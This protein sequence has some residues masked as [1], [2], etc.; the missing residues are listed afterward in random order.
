MKIVGRRS[1]AFAHVVE[2]LAPLPF[3]LVPFT[4]LMSWLMRDDLPTFRSVV[5]ISTSVAAAIAAVAARALAHRTG[6]DRADNTVNVVVV[7]AALAVASSVFGM[8]TWVASG[9]EFTTLALFMLFPAIACAIGASV[10]AGRRWMYCAFLFPSVMWTPLGMWASDDPRLRGMTYIA[11]FYLAC[12][13]VVHQVATR[14][15]MEA[16]RF[17]SRSEALLVHLGDER[18][19]LGAVNAQ[20]SASNEMLAQLASN[21]PLTGLLNRRGTFDAIDRMLEDASRPV[22]LLFC[23]LDRFKSVNDALGHRGGDQFLKVL[24][25][26]IARSLAPG[27]V[28]GRIG[29]DEFVVALPGCDA[30]AS[31]VIAARLLAVLAQPV[32]AE[33]RDLPSSVSIGVAEFPAHGCTAND[34]LRNA[35]T[36]LYRAKRSGRSR[37]EMFDAAMQAERDEQL[38]AEHALRRAIENGEILPFFQPEID[39]STGRIVGAEMLARWLRPDGTVTNAADFIALAKR[40][41]LLERLTERMILQARPQIRR[42]ASLGLPDGFRFRVNLPPSSTTLSWREDPLDALVR[43]IDASLLTVDVREAAVAD[44]IPTAAAT[45]AAFR[46]RGGRVCLDDFA[47]GVSSLSLLRSLADRRGPDRPQGDRRDHCPPAR[48]RDRPIDHRGRA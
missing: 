17:Q 5:W 34:L 22:G 7:G 36:A 32:H 8:S 43:G 19:A 26:R 46:E 39:A 21:D 1:R 15:F 6:L 13:I 47:R 30:A 31:S 23:D 10:C 33:G 2:N 4:L 9:S 18:R 12:M 27:A 42:L 44:D 20:L 45:L 37:V 41:G 28:A 16:L 35:N 38:D 48:P 11:A 14:T 25:D 24:A 3:L 29:G 40:A